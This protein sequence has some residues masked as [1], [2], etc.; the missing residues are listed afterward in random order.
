MNVH[1][2]GQGY[3]VLLRD[4]TDERCGY[5]VVSDESVVVI[6]QSKVFTCEM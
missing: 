2:D 1:A 4:M 6:R 3:D 5:A